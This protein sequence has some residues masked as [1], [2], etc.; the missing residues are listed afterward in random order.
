M[1]VDSS[2][3]SSFPDTLVFLRLVCGSSAADLSRGRTELQAYGYEHL[4]SLN[5]LQVIGFLARRDQPN[6][7]QHI[8]FPALRRALKLV[9]DD[10]DDNNPTDIAY[11]Y[12][13]SGC[14]EHASYVCP[15]RRDDSC[16]WSA[17]THH[18]RRV[19]QQEQI[20]VPDSDCR[21][22]FYMFPV[23]GTRR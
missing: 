2:I 1:Y 19:K 6:I 21:G 7:K 20:D 3:S 9:V 22:A 17:D 14:V 16:W 23:A 18:P 4:V 8:N 12:S 15:L 13:H 5:N 11:A 10:L